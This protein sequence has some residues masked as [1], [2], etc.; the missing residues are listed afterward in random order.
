M[1]VN[2]KNIYIQK[3]ARND[4]FEVKNIFH[5]MDIASCYRKRE[6]HIDFE[7]HNVISS[8]FV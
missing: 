6:D 1:P 4:F 2:K 5:H 7:K 8:Q 3:L